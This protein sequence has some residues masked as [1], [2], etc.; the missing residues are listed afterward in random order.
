MVGGLRAPDGP[1]LRAARRHEPGDPRRAVDRVPPAGPARRARSA[2]AARSIGR[3]KPTPARSGR[4]RSSG[5]TSPGRS[6]PTALSASAATSSRPTGPG[7]G[8]RWTTTT[9]GCS[10]TPC[11]ACPSRGR[12]GRADAASTTCA[13]TARSRSA[14]SARRSSCGP[15]AAEEV[16]AARLDERTGVVLQ[17]ATPAPPPANIV[18]VPSP[19]SGA[20]GRAV[21]VLRGRRSRGSASGRLPASSSSTRRRSPSTA[22]PSWPFRSTSR[23]TSIPSHIDREANEFVL[24][25]TYRLPTLIHTR[26]ANAKWLVEISHSNPT[27]MHY[28]R[29]DSGWA[30]RPATSSGS[31]PQIGHFVDKRL[32]H[33]GDPPGRRRLLAPP[34]PLAPG[35]GGRGEPPRL[36]ARRAVRV[37]RGAGTC[38]QVAGR[39]ALQAP[40]IPTPS[41][42]GGRTPACTRT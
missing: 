2:W 12:A 11:P 22:G 40:P 7:S 34:R 30:S 15:L 19:A 27:W 28:L 42:S 16:A 10:R 4:R 6:T 3:T 1:R 17:L 33:G 41:A 35:G 23:A 32:G 14:R 39:R 26:S 5:S 36:R 8:S 21:G 29:R 20:D 24:L 37:A 38:R 25:S 13:S 18:P 31:R 9:A